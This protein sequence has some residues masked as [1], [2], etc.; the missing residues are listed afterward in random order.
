MSNVNEWRE[1]YNRFMNHSTE[2]NSPEFEDPATDKQI[3]LL[4]NLGYSDNIPY[5]KRECRALI[6][7]LLDQEANARNIQGDVYDELNRYGL[8]QSDTY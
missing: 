2:W 4:I 5:S 1:E 8:D 7:K 3:K 6:S